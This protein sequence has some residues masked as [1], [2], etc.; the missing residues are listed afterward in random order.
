VESPEI[1]EP[2]ERDLTLFKKKSKKE[3]KEKERDRQQDDFPKPNR[4]IIQV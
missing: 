1:E 2:E 3:E 4:G